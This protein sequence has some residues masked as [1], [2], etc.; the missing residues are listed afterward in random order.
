M[1]TELNNP[2]RITHWIDGAPWSGT[3]ARAGDVFNPATGQVSGRV[4][5]ASSAEVDEAVAAAAAA[6]QP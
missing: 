2:T 1:A 3:S 5:L 4:D 6:F